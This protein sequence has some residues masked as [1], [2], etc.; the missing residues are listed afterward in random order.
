MPDPWPT[1]AGAWCILHVLAAATGTW[2]AR[3]YALRRDLL[4]HPGERRSHLLATPRGGGIGIVVAW[5]AAWLLLPL[6]LRLP[7][8]LVAAVALGLLLVAGAGWIDDHRP[9]SPWVRLAAHVL[10]G[11][12]LAAACAA[13]GAGIA[14]TLLA[15]AAVPVLVNVWNF[16]DGIDGLAASQ[17]ALA[18]TAYALLASDPATVAMALSLAAACLGFLPFNFPRARIFLGDVGSGALGFILAVLLVATAWSAPGGPWAWPMLLL[19]LSAFLLDASLTLAGRIVRGEKWWAAHVE[20]AY[21]RLASKLESHRPVTLAYACWTALA[22]A[23]VAGGA[24]SG[25][26]TAFN[27]CVAIAW[28]GAGAL[29]WLGLS[30]HSLNQQDIV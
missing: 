4:D 5:L 19:P 8:P 14:V 22:V 30:R 6:V 20:H 13:A 18:A 12:L 27:M 10:A 17:A 29:V 1:W 9:L 23:L 25:W 26:A 11:A 24:S 16:M 2:L 21:Q 15:F 3:R 28:F 7:A